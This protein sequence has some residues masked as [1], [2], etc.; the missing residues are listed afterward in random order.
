M[1]KLDELTLGQ[2]KEIKNLVGGDKILTHPYNLGK[3][4]FIQTVTHY[5]VGTLLQVTESELVLENASWVGDTGR[6]TDFFKKGVDNLS[7]EVE[8]FPKGSVIVGRG[9]CGVSL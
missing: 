7:L 9:C 5:Y 2:I 1:I 3:N 4:Y 8:L 6:F